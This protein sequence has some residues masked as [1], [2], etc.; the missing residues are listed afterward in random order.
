[1]LRSKSW[2]GL[3]LLVGLSAISL[4]G[5]EPPRRTTTVV[6][7]V[8]TT[9]VVPPVSS[10]QPVV[11]GQLIP[12]ANVPPLHSSS[13]APAHGAVP[14]VPSHGNCPSC[15]VAA[16]PSSGGCAS[17]APTPA[18]DCIDCAGEDEDSGLFRRL[19]GGKSQKQRYG[20]AAPLGC[21]TFHSDACFLFGSC[22][23]FFGK[24]PPREPFPGQFQPP[25]SPC[26]Y[27]TF[28]RY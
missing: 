8:Q 20:C 23:Q 26:Y 24:R 18:N 25:T 7:V 12:P 1:M 14:P 3:S 11:N 17:C 21:G 2:F 5:A 19:F 13:P 10:A 4:F 22:R 9:P 16:P 6:P 15:A 27:G 28:H